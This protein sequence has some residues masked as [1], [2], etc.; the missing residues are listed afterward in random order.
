[1]QLLLMLNLTWLEKVLQ[2]LAVVDFGLLLF[3]SVF[4]PRNTTP[5][6]LGMMVPQFHWLARP[7][8]SVLF[9]MLCALVGA[10]LALLV[11]RM[12]QWGT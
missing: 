6:P 4:L 8:V 3:V 5:V 2:P 10:G 1:M 9:V 11:H 7:L 12:R